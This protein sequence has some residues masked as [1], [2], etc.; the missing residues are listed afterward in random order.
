MDAQVTWDRLL[1]AYAAG[2]WDTIEALAGG[3]RF[4]LDCGGAPP[5]VIALDDFEDWNRV[6]ADAGC[7]HAQS[8]LREQWCPA[9]TAVPPGETE[10]CDA[11]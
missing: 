4:W 9:G 1:A 3:L 6:L 11:R 10:A 2:D 5:R 7:R 8:V